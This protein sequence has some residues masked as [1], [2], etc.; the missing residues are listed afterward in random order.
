MRSTTVQLAK[1]ST[2]VCNVRPCDFLITFLFHKVVS[3]GAKI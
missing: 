2:R 1:C 3:Y